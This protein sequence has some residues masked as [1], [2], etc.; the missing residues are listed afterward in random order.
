[1][2]RGPKITLGVILLAAAILIGW[3]IAGFHADKI[4]AE[5][6]ASGQHAHTLQSIPVGPEV[7]QPFARTPFQGTSDPRWEKWKLGRALDPAYEWKTPIE[8]YGMVLDESDKPVENAQVEIEWSGTT[9][10]HRSESVGRRTQ[11]S[12]AEGLFEITGIRGK[13]MLVD[14][15]KDGYFKQKP[16]NNGRFEYAGFWEPTFIEP[17][18]DNPVVFRLIRRPEAEPT[19]R[20]GERLLLPP[21]IWSTHIDLLAKPAETVQ[22]GDMTLRILRPPN[23]GHRTP[24]DWELKI[25]GNGDTEFVESTDEF[26]LR[27]PVGGYKKHL[28]KEYRQVKGSAESKIELYVRSRSRKFYAAVTFIVTPYYP[29]ASVDKACIIVDATV[30]PNDSPNVVYDPAKNIR[31]MAEK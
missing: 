28:I 31:E 24:I 26:M 9:E 30:N 13:M 16:P 8:F 17:E 18:R 14:V 4:D 23:P 12:N 19:L 10:L 7:V 11:F 22:G 3:R 21:P 6:N 2:I 1:M 20:V 29:M 15:K 27:A 25:E 5:Y